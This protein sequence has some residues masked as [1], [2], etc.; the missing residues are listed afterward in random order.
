MMEQS[1]PEP[2]VI[3][4]NKDVPFVSKIAELTKKLYFHSLIKESARSKHYIVEDISNLSAPTE[5]VFYYL[6]QTIFQ[7]PKE[8]AYAHR[9][10]A[11]FFN[12]CKSPLA[13]SE[14]AK[15][16]R[17]YHFTD[18]DTQ[19]YELV[20]IYEYG[21]P[22]RINISII[23]PEQILRFIKNIC[24]LLQDVYAFNQ[25]THGNL[26]L[27]N[28]VLC[29]KELKI[30]GFKP[31]YTEPPADQK[32]KARVVKK[33]GALRL[34][35]FLTGLVW[36]NFLD[37]NMDA[38]LMQGKSLEEIEKEL[39]ALLPKLQNVKKVELLERLLSLSKV[40]T[41]SME[42][43]LLE[44]DEYF[45]LERI[46]MS[47]Q[48]TAQE[49][50]TIRNSFGNETANRPDLQADLSSRH[51]NRY[52]TEDLEARLSGKEDDNLFKRALKDSD[53]DPDGHERRSFEFGNGASLGPGNFRTN[54]DF[55][56]NEHFS[57]IPKDDPEKAIRNSQNV[58]TAQLNQGNKSNASFAVSE[59]ATSEKPL[60]ADFNFQSLESE[61]SAVR[62]LTGAASPDGYHSNSIKIDGTH[63]TAVNLLSVEGNSKSSLN[64]AASEASAQ[65]SKPKTGSVSAGQIGNATNVTIE[66]QIAK[67]STQT[68]TSK[69]L[70]DKPADLKISD[71]LDVNIERK[72]MQATVTE[73]AQAQA[74][75]SQKSKLS[76][77]LKNTKLKPI[78]EALKTSVTKSPN[79][80]V[81]ELSK[82]GSVSGGR[83]LEAQAQ[84]VKGDFKK[85]NS[86]VKQLVAESTAATTKKASVAGDSSP[87]E[88]KVGSNRKVTEKKQTLLQKIQL[89]PILKPGEMALEPRQSADQ[90]SL[91]EKIRS[92]SRSK[93]A[94]EKPIQEELRA[95]DQLPVPAT[96][97]A[98]E[99]AEAQE[100]VLGPKESEV[101]AEATF[102]Q[103]KVQAE[104]DQSPTS[105]P[106][107]AEHV[108]PVQDSL[109]NFADV[110]SLE[111]SR[112]PNAQA[113]SKDSVPS[114]RNP[115]ENRKSDPADLS[116]FG[117][118]AK[119]FQRKGDPASLTADKTLSNLDPDIVSK[120]LLKKK[121][122]QALK[123]KSERQMQRQREIEAFQKSQREHEYDRRIDEILQHNLQQRLIHEEEKTA[124]Q[125]RVLIVKQTEKNSKNQ[126]LFDRLK[127]LAEERYTERKHGEMENWRNKREFLD[128]IAREHE[129]FEEFKVRKPKGEREVTG[130]LRELEA[131]QAVGESEGPRKPKRGLST[132]T[133]VPGI[134]RDRS[135][136]TLAPTKKLSFALTSIEE[137]DK[138]FR[139]NHYH[140]VFQIPFRKVVE[141]FDEGVAAEGESKSR[142]VE[143]LK[144]MHKTVSASAIPKKD[145]RKIID[146]FEDTLKRY[147][148]QSFEGVSG[149]IGDFEKGKLPAGL[150]SSQAGPVSEGGS[151]RS[152][153]SAQKYAG[154]ID[155]AAFASKLKSAGGFGSA[156]SQAYWTPSKRTYAPEG[157]P[158]ELDYS[159]I[160]Y[161]DFRNQALPN[162]IREYKDLSYFKNDQI[163]L[164]DSNDPPG[165]LRDLALYCQTMLN[166]GKLEE[167]LQKVHERT[168][169]LK[170][171]DLV[172]LNKIIAS[173][174]FATG[175]FE[176]AKEELLN[177]IE[178]VKTL[179]DENKVQ[180]ELGEL[181]FNLSFLEFMI[182][183]I[184]D[185]VEMLR[186]VAVER[187]Y[188]GKI[189]NIKGNSLVT[190]NKPKGA[191]EAYLAE[192]TAVL[193]QEPK[194]PIMMRV[195]Q[196]IC[197]ILETYRMEKDKMGPAA[198]YQQV[199][200]QLT[201]V[202]N[203]YRKLD[204]E[205]TKPYE[206]FMDLMVLKF[207]AYGNDN[208]NWGMMNYVLER[209]LK[210][211]TLSSPEELSPTY[212]DE[213]CRYALAVCDYLKKKPNFGG[214]ERNYNT[215]LQLA[216]K[217]VGASEVSIESLKLNLI[218]LFNKGIFLLQTKEATAAR[219]LFTECF[220]VLKK[221]FELE[222]SGVYALI[223][224]MAKTLL[225]QRDFENAAFFYEEFKK[226]GL[227]RLDV[228][229]KVD[230]KL[231]KLYFWDHK[232]E[233]CL[234]LL[235]PF[236]KAN[237]FNATRPELDNKIM[238]YVAYM[239]MASYYSKATA[240]E[241]TQQS[242]ERK[243]IFT[244]HPVY[245]QYVVLLK[246][247]DSFVNRPESPAENAK[248]LRYLDTILHSK[249]TIP[250]EKGS[251][252]LEFVSVIFS[253]HSK[254]HINILHLLK[255]NMEDTKANID[256][257]CV[258]VENALFIV[259]TA[260]KTNQDYSSR[261]KY[262]LHKLYTNSTVRE[263]IRQTVQ[264]NWDITEEVEGRYISLRV[265]ELKDRIAEQLLERNERLKER[266]IK[267]KA[268][269]KVAADLPDNARDILRRSHFNRADC[270]C[271]DAELQRYS[272][273]KLIEQFLRQLKNMMYLDV[274]D[275]I[276][277]YYDRFEKI[278]KE[279]RWNWHKFAYIPL[280]FNLSKQTEIDGSLD[281]MK[282]LRI[283][284]E[285]FKGL[286]LCVH[287]LKM[288]VLLFESFKKVEYLEVFVMY[289]HKMH[290]KLASLLFNWVFLENFTA[291]W[292]V[293]VAE[294][295][296][297]LYAFK[298]HAFENFPLMHFL[299][300]E[301]VLEIEK[302]LGF[303][304]Y[305]RYRWDVLADPRF[306]EL[307]LQYI[308]SQSL[309]LFCFRFA[310]YK[311][312]V[313]LYKQPSI[314]QA[315]VLRSYQLQ[316][317]NHT[318]NLIVDDGNYQ[319]F[320]YEFWTLVNFVNLRT[321]PN[322]GVYIVE[323]VNHLKRK[324]QKTHSYHL[325]VLA[326]SV[327]NYFFKY[328]LF[329][330]SV[331]LKTIALETLKNVEAEPSEY[332]EYVQPMDQKTVLFGVLA[333]LYLDFVQ[334]EDAEQSTIFIGKL[335][336]YDYENEVLN[337][338][339]NLLFALSLLLAEQI[340]RGI[341]VMFKCKEDFA[342]LSLRDK[343]QDMFQAAIDKLD[344][345]ISE[346]IDPKL[347]VE[348]KR[349]KSRQS[350]SKLLQV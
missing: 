137:Q 148:E 182:G 188:P 138:K 337:L 108:G 347:I 265:N 94:P 143:K 326:S 73:T 192:L 105:R 252:V 196:L 203:L 4:G 245:L 350:I 31:I 49:V 247:A 174:L 13:K 156:D 240:F 142:S 103:V 331:R 303:R 255:A 38:I 251:E 15:L 24:L 327:G 333:F 145:Q 209:A 88:D 321:N 201:Q 185:S 162:P 129:P 295:S 155:E 55:V 236:L 263:E 227:Q 183:D 117:V 121:T 312:I 127:R 166:D 261:A 204:R 11:D 315:E 170:G 242:L 291:K 216:N 157:A 126:E 147:K 90:K 325:A 51:S 89:N 150:V 186:N 208:Q 168:E 293:I 226:L 14:I 218:L 56:L 33:Y 289:L 71:K 344:L 173:I 96:N 36:L 59:V 175:D 253:K 45:V 21:D 44:F 75:A 47:K 343:L 1:A 41:M 191:R 279:K 43:V 57:M 212:R 35:F 139:Y 190:L 29:D 161:V 17:I 317:F 158:N 254:E 244:R 118:H 267:L 290:P 233:A 239:R 309:E 179:N 310:T 311:A 286:A 106:A 348:E 72:S 86:A 184:A 237:L 230:L 68:R 277:S 345:M 220:G 95:P 229:E 163:Y 82:N 70:F 221:L 187:R 154:M 288:I 282:L 112:H 77:D 69:K 189:A 113:N 336:T 200:A 231:A 262:T 52:S 338:E 9:Y 320:V 22:D 102:K 342:K 23:E 98:A 66:T 101:A 276:L 18:D 12:Y 110:L 280:L 140:K 42:N 132:H 176:R 308:D 215:Y 341:G 6:K 151:R 32:W 20:T 217:L 270:G 100:S 241:D 5:P 210:N 97:I 195:Y 3:S 165:K 314:S 83:L 80:P 10:Y 278:I 93:S 243:A 197:K 225:K 34:D 332:P 334:L 153:N 54:P 62:R 269:Q 301:S 7:T 335:M 294:L 128:H 211:K 27:R 84:E 259:N 298:F 213:L 53:K 264:N 205:A 300:F 257:V 302:D 214:F 61:N 144:G 307:F 206:G 304:I 119:L 76:A 228:L 306:R 25:V 328:K 167:L 99:G 178:N 222:A 120:A 46:S 149:A 104:F 223:N 322:A 273:T 194:L 141:K 63:A 207:L 283:L 292:D 268:E 40:P 177:A 123:V 28:I 122:E 346:G 224:N 260:L 324:V 19:Y 64:Q 248:V 116:E 313:T 281:R 323:I 81:K 193:K 30:S 316:L 2:L 275:D 169:Q 296:R 131:Q 92:D 8:M 318:Q 181:I 111:E 50:E 79:F 305:R 48:S 340:E 160:R 164:P 250:L 67:Q 266:D 272:P 349:K 87:V 134:K 125:K 256:A 339:K 219:Q 39:L 246:I 115:Q 78:E 171:A 114:E 235:E 91:Q 85:K 238:K 172:D 180:K 16:L 124:E 271:S 274:T 136:N 26:H 285:V 159:H 146:R 130:E 258:F 297:R 107:K 299:N 152:F 58:E 234:Q 198:F 74:E 37:V 135:E 133:F 330:D 329:K 199:E 287:D 109:A 284:D 319:F 60:K 65:Q 249:T 232:F 202:S